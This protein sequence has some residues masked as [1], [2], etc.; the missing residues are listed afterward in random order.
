MSLEDSVTL[1]FRIGSYNIS[2]I[3]QCNALDFSY[4]FDSRTC[5]TS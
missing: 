5:R 1:S 2:S 4:H 3:G